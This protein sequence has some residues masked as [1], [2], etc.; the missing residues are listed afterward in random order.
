MR[1]RWSKAHKD[2]GRDPWVPLDDLGGVQDI[3]DFP[4]Q[5]TGKYFD[6]QANR[7]FYSKTEKREWMRKNKIV[8]FVPS[9]SNPWKGLPE[10]GDHHYKKKHFVV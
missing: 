3:I 4:D 9:W 1:Y 8:E 6:V 5:G 10:A 7:W 2:A